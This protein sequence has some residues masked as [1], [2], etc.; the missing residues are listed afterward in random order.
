MP[1]A[2]ELTRALKAERDAIL[3]RF[4]EGGLAALA[5]LLWY[6]VS[7]EYDA[8]HLTDHLRGRQAAGERFG[9]AFWRAHG[10]WAEEER[11][12]HEGFLVALE[13]LFGEVGRGAAV[14]E[15]PD[16]PEGATWRELLA[17]RRYDPAPLG[18]VLA[19]E[20]GV[21]VC[22][23]YDE[24]VTVRAYRANLHVY[25]R[26]GQL[27]ARFVRA[28]IA[29]EALHYARFLEVLVADHPGALGEVAGRLAAVRATGAVAP[30][31]NM[32]LLDHHGPE[33]TAALCE[34]AARALLARVG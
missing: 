29:D 25:D 10:L 24:L 21:L 28:V 27:F 34:S 12:H 11:R 2:A 4:D 6:D 19:D 5:D 3:A 26:L 7:T 9:E 22:G 1:T 30:Y 20:V 14:A 16:V 17:A 31:G 32:F 13:V 33:Y 18:G 8:R 23:A 15:T